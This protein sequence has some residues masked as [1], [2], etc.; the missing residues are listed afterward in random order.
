LWQKGSKEN[1]TT[2][3]A[4]LPNIASIEHRTLV[5]VKRAIPIISITQTLKGYKYNSEE[6]NDSDEVASSM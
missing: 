1:K 6:K 2:K 4:K 5:M 3:H